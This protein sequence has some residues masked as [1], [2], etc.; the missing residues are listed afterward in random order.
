[1]IPSDEKMLIKSGS[2]LRSCSDI[3]MSANVLQPFPWLSLLHFEGPSII[4]Q[5]KSSQCQGSSQSSK[6]GRENLLL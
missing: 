1:M 5:T 6:E 3:N 2:E 4:Y